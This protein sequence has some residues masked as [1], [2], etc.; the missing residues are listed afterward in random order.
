MNI[1][2]LIIGAVLIGSAIVVE[3]AFELRRA[4]SLEGDLTAQSKEEC[5]IPLMKGKKLPRERNPFLLTGKRRWRL[6]SM[7][8]TVSLAP[9]TRPTVQL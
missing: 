2:V 3:L 4:R 1:P 7:E 9:R 5:V 6:I 8:R